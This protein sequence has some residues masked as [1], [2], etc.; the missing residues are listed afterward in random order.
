MGFAEGAGSYGGKTLDR[1]ARFRYDLDDEG[2]IA[3]N[4]DGTISVAWWLRD[5]TGEWK[6]WM[7]NTFRRLT[8]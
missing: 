2:R 4:A 6:P 7:G 8:G 5:Q 3:T 1:P